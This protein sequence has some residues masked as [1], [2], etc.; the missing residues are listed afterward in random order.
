MLWKC[1][2]DNFWLILLIALVLLALC[3]KDKLGAALGGDV[4]G[5]DD[6]VEAYDEDGIDE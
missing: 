1:L 5:G 6:W 3:Y 2:K 4:F